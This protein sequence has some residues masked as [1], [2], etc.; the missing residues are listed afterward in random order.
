MMKV[1]LNAKD[2]HSVTHWHWVTPNHL[3]I[4]RAMRRMTGSLKLRV[5]KRPKVR[6][7]AK[8]TPKVTLKSRVRS[9]VTYWLR[10]ILNV[11]A[12]LRAMATTKLRVT[13]TLTVTPRATHWAMLMT[14]VKLTARG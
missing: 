11:T 1:T 8:V 2:S 13:L 4:L 3:A 7:R 14:M 6:L 12:I 10:V 9:R 5:I